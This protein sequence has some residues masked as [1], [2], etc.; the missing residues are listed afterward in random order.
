MPYADKIELEDQIEEIK[1]MFKLINLPTDIRSLGFDELVGGINSDVLVGHR[2][3]PVNA[4]DLKK[5]LTT[6]LAQ[7]DAINAKTMTREKGWIY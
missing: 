5:D 3:R 1:N 7:V 4:E 2:L 6:L